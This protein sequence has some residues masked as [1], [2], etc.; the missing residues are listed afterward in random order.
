VVALVAA[1]AGRIGG[2]VLIILIGLI[3]LI[4]GAHLALI[5]C[6][7]LIAGL[8][9]VDLVDVSLV[10]LIDVPQVALVELIDLADLIRLGTDQFGREEGMP[11][12]GRGRVGGVGE[13]RTHGECQEGTRHE[14]DTAKPARL[15]GAR[16]HL[17]LRSYR[18]GAI[19]V[20]CMVE[21][22]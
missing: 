11:R 15:N 16:F 9:L 13:C 19:P 20:L 14:D 7:G 12:R 17:R 22:P 2:V 8:A 21:S 5:A 3:G 6:G 18:P 4:G 1:L 10:G